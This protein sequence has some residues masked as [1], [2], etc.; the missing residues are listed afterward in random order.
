MKMKKEHYSRLNDMIKTYA[1]PRRVEILNA[2]ANDTRV[3]DS[4]RRF[5]WDCYWTASRAYHAETAL[6]LVFIDELYSYLNDSHI[7]TALKKII[8]D[9][10]INRLFTGE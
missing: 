10:E 5:R 6:W 2:I 9:L 7:D 4:E 1:W 3:K 8:S